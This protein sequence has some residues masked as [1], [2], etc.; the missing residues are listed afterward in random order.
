MTYSF[1]SDV[2]ANK[3]SKLAE[4][5]TIRLKDDA[6]PVQ[7]PPRRIQVPLRPLLKAALNSLSA[8]GIIAPISEPTPWISSLVVAPKKN[9]KLRICLDPKNLNQAIKRENYV[10]PT[11]EEVATRLHGARYFTVFDL[12][13]AFWQIELDAESAKLTAFHTPYGRYIWLRMPFGINSASEVLQRRMHQLT[14]G[15]EGVDVVADDF[16]VYGKGHTDDEAR[17]DHDRNLIAFLNRARQHCIVL[18]KDKAKLRERSTSFIGHVITPEGLAAAPERIK[19]LQD[20]PTP[21]DVTGVRRFI[22]FV[23]YLAKFMP[24]LAAEL[25][26]L[27]TLLH[28][29]AEWKWGK[30]QEVAVSHV[31]ALASKAPVLRYYNLHD[32]V[33]IQCDA[34]KDGLG[35]A[36]LQNGQ[37]VCYAS[38][39]MTSAE[40]RYAQI[41]KECLAIVFACEKFDVYIYGRDTVTVESDHKPLETIFKNQLCDAPKR[42]QKMLMRLR[43]YS[44]NVTFKTRQRNVHC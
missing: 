43:R 30:E 5:Y 41:E 37:P 35:A 16:V 12:K 2:F 28:Q 18:G 23:Q 27:T 13:S 11:I 7:Q 42:L 32:E 9:G 39:A 29:D 17:A 40:T 26:P 20:M 24:S 4:P 8:E 6:T 1:N 44:L 14:E 34:S 22:G 21:T 36:L 25:K 3:I 19:A 15:L 38:R 10:M 31:K 33:T